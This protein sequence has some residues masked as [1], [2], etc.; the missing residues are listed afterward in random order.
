MEFGKKLLSRVLNIDLLLSGTALI[1]LIIATFSGVIMRYFLNNPYTWL[2]EFQLW[3]FVWVVFFGASAAF[4]SGS[5]VAIEILVDL[6][7]DKIKKVIE[8]FGYLVVTG[9]LVYFT[10]NGTG[11]VKQLL[12]TGRLTNI[13]KIPFPVIY[14]ALPI[15]CILMIISNT[16]MTWDSLF[17]DKLNLEGGDR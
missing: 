13:L 17:N 4:R 2:E 7:P 8:I 6:L 12:S 14:S 11:L 10:I 1:A 16:L 3:C 15:G 9:V 5:H